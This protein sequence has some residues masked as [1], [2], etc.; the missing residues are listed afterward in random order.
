MYKI[1]K[2]S[3]LLQSG[4]KLFHTQD[5]EVLWGINNKNTL[6]VTVNRFI[7]RKILYKIIKGLYSTIPI[8]QIDRYKLGTVL[9]NKFCYISCETV[10]FIEG[11]INQYIY[12]V[13]YVSP[14]SLR[15]NNDDYIRF[16]YRQLK[17]E[18]LLNPEGVKKENGY[19]IATKE[20]AVADMLY[21]RPRYY[22]DNPESVDW[23]LVA[24]IQKNVGYKIIR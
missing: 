8:D 7:K 20:R 9:I 5:L 10:L 2:Q 1:N 22:L 19:L 24:K 3:V 17:S 21:F 23:K 4:Q 13:T 18:F 6:Y 11:V 15:I 12:P 14:V 16:S